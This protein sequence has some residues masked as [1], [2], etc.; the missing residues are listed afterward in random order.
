MSSLTYVILAA[1]MPEEMVAKFK[2][3]KQDLLAKSKVCTTKVHQYYDAHAKPHPKASSLLA[4]TWIDAYADI[5]VDST[6]KLVF[7]EAYDGFEDRQEMSGLY[8]NEQFF[9]WLATF[10]VKGVIEGHE[11]GVDDHWKVQFIRQEGK[12]K[13]SRIVSYHYDWKRD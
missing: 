10:K 11:D 2:K 13:H 3:A 1:K 12:R 7:V 9:K 8:H 6:G 5:D 4:Q